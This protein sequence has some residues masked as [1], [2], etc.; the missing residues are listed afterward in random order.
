MSLIDHSRGKGKRRQPKRNTFRFGD[1]VSLF[2][3]IRSLA[4]THSDLS[5]IE[6]G[7]S[8]GGDLDSHR[9]RGQRGRRA[10]EELMLRR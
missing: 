1:K 2:M 8:G 3:V 7:G 6:S 10:R 4:I 9:R 5:R